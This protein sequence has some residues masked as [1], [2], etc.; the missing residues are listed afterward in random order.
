MIPQHWQPHYRDQDDE[1]TGYL[2]PGAEP[3]TV[4]PVTLFGYPLAEAGDEDDAADV[5]DARGLSVLA[6]RWYLHADGA[7]PVRVSI[8]E[9][10]PQR[11]VVQG[12]DYG[13]IDIDVQRYEFDNPVPEGILRL[14]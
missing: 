2:V 5:L 6:D 4:V 13:A 12:F 3:G 7:D 9:V 14:H 1:L 10:T 8:V 11:V